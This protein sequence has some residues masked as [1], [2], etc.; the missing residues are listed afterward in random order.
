[1]MVEAPSLD[2]CRDVCARLVD[3]IG[4]ELA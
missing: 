2:E 1:V 4:R 3:L